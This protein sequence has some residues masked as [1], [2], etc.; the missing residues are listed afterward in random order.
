[1]MSPGLEDKRD[2][3]SVEGPSCSSSVARSG[4]Q[5]TGVDADGGEKGGYL[6]T[7]CWGRAEDLYLLLLDF[8]GWSTFEL[9]R[10]RSLV[11]STA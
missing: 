8:V 4:W 10:V 2:D 6:L 9:R 3:V 1:M 7:S 5:V 11:G